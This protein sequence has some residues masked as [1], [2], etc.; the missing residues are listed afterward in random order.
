MKVMV[1][2]VH[3]DDEAL[4][5]GGTLLKHKAKG[6]EIA[7][8][9]VT[10]VLEEY[11]FS[12]ELRE[13][14]Q[15]EINQVMKLTGVSTL[16]DLHYNPGLLDST[17]LPGLIKEISAAITKFQPE[18]VYVPNR[19]DAH[20]DHRVTFDAVMACTKTFR[21][22]FVK[23][24]LMYECISET[25]FAPALAEN[26]FVPNYFVN[27]TP[28]LKGKLAVLKVYA[29]E[30]GEHPFPRSERNVE[31]LAVFRGATCGVEYAEA[32]QLLKFIED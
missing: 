29:S 27:I 12:T 3:P 18:V 5:C 23:R 7:W 10:N 24:V 32:F 1:I 16:F 22:P 31:A 9:I 17:K 2:S 6:D 28:H 30:L 25:E 19:S 21:Y 14:V 20:S 11:G 4:G 15:S 8:L 13:S 26:A